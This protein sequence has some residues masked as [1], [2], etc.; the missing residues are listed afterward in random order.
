MFIRTRRITRHLSLCLFAAAIASMGSTAL[1]QSAE[2]QPYIA[3]VTKDQI[4]VH[5]GADSRYYPFCTL[6]E[7]DL[8]EV[9]GE[10]SG[11]AR[12]ATAGAA[13]DGVFGYIK[14]PRSDAGRFRLEDNKQTGVTLGM[15]DLIAPNMN[16][17]YSP[18][19]SWKPLGGKLPAGHTVRVLETTETDREIVHKVA[20]PA[21]ASGW[22]NMIHL[23][24]ATA[25]EVA[26]WE[27]ALG[28]TGRPIEA[29]TQAST[30]REVQPVAPRAMDPVPD[31]QPLPSGGEIVDPAT[32]PAL[33]PSLAGNVQP[34]TEMTI[35]EEEFNLWH[36]KLLNLEDAF[37]ALSVSSP[38][39]S[40][41]VGPLR[42]KYEDMAMAAA[43]EEP[44]ISSFAARR[45]TQLAVWSEVQERK[46]DL[47]RLKQR[48]QV[49]TEDFDAAKMAIAMSGDYAAVGRLEASSVYNGK[50]L[51]ELYRVQDEKSGRTIAYLKPDAEFQ[52]AGLLGQLVGIAGEIEYDGTL[53]VNMLTPRHVD[54]L[55]P[56]KTSRK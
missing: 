48:V 44:V 27:A 14:Y 39:E 1:A 37:M 21:E 9:T 38:R 34:S 22:T 42:N 15:M 36:E 16:E 24:K 32:D 49:A 17:N 54:V 8:V 43:E 5:S 46:A 10:K 12:I 4:F 13:F 52:L 25:A 20:L 47:A 41:D 30:S 56:K 26:A 7:G 19:H 6:D 29:K 18:E 33:N 2:F 28:T 23:R 40:A 51:P 53:R 31:I 11:W 3:A 35:E 55:A 50:S 45:A